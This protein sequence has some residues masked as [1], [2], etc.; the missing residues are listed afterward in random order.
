MYYLAGTM[1]VLL[2]LFAPAAQANSPEDP[3]MGFLNALA[4]L[5]SEQAVTYV[6][7]TS[8]DDIDQILSMVKAVDDPRAMAAQ[9]GVDVEDGVIEDMT[10]REFLA[11]LLNEPGFATINLVE[12]DVVDVEVEGDR[13]EVMV[14]GAY[15]DEVSD[16]AEVPVVREDGTWKISV[17]DWIGGPA[18][19]S[20]N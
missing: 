2:L 18:V 20:S 3:V 13:G 1:C 17:R 19:P 4:E 14:V 10:A 9:I 16:V 11:E 7:R 8:L 6:S 15:F 12:L 5:D